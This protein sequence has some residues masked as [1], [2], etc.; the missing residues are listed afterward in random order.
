M[1]YL[2]NLLFSLALITSAR[3]QTTYES[4]HVK[5]GKTIQCQIPD[6]FHLIE[7][8]SNHESKQYTSNPEIDFTEV[9]TDTV[10][11]GML[12]V[13]H[14][15]VDGETLG[16]LLKKLSEQV[17]EDAGIVVARS[18]DIEDINGRQFILTA[19]LDGVTEG[20]LERIFIGI[21][22]FG[23]YFIN[24]IYYS[25]ELTGQKLNLSS[26]SEIL[27]TWTEVTTDKEDAME[28]DGLSTEE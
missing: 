1:K 4:P 23:D 19:Y 21:T 28:S 13:F 9:D 3:A 20:K 27:E 7:V 5:D 16:S 25:T 10:E 24:T 17:E 6:D 14:A 26:F 8:L 18:P 2:L 11:F 22:Q 12:S 15:P